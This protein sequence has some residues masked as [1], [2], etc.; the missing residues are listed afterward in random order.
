MGKT[1]PFGTLR[2]AKPLY[3]IHYHDQISP[4]Q[5]ERQATTN[6]EIYMD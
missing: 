1:K 3:L 4:D 6:K 2:I 5:R